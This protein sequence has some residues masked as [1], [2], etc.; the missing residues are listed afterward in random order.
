MNQTSKEERSSAES[1]ERRVRAK[2]NIAPSS[3]HLTQ[4]G[5]RAFQGLRNVRVAAA[6]ANPPRWEPYAV[7]PL[8]RFCAVAISD[9]RPYRDYCRP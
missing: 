8:V 3:T 5:E 4:S 2:E 9:D 7:M 6:F 1:G